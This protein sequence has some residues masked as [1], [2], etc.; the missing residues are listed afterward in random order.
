MACKT[1]HIYMLPASE[2]LRTLR[3]RLHQELIC[4]HADEPVRPRALEELP[5][6]VHVSGRAAPADHRRVLRLRSIRVLSGDAQSGVLS[7]AAQSGA[8][9][10]ATSTP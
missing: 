10:C 8:G 7:G 9:R 3:V 5:G 4:R 2:A 6:L 1:K